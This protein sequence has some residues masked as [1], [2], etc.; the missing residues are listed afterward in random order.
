MRNNTFFTTFYKNL[1]II[2]IAAIAIIA[3]L[4]SFIIFAIKHQSRKQNFVKIHH[5]EI[6]ELKNQINWI[7]F[8]KA[9]V[10]KNRYIVSLGI[11]TKT[12][13]SA[14][15]IQKIIENS[16]IS[17]NKFTVQLQNDPQ[18]TR[19]NL[20]LLTFDSKEKYNPEFGKII[21][22][23]MNSKY[24]DQEYEKIAN[25]TYPLMIKIFKNPEKGL[26]DYEMS[27]YSQYFSNA[28]KKKKK[29]KYISKEDFVRFLEF[30]KQNQKI[31]IEEEKDLDLLIL[32]KKDQ[33]STLYDSVIKSSSSASRSSSE[34]SV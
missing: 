21:N 4:S 32:T 17:D 27:I 20:L 34:S 24:I 1:T 9:Y 18:N 2:A 11:Q 15:N 16:T 14:Q 8:D 31:D 5:K 25:Q 23:L 12:I 26:D 33:R 30:C 10:K 6:D 13:E 22:K 28:Q 19:A 29:K 7:K 3:L